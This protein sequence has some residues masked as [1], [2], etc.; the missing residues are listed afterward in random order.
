MNPEEDF[1]TWCGDFI[2]GEPTRAHGTVFCDAACHSG[3]Q[4]APQPNLRLVTDAEPTA[5]TSPDLGPI[6]P[7]HATD[8]WRLEG[9]DHD[10]WR[11]AKRFGDTVAMVV[12]TA[13]AIAW[14]L[15]KSGKV[16]RAASEQDVETAK[17]HATAWI[18]KQQ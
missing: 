13:S 10:R 7:E 1:C 17:A 3:Y 6:R 8:G 12:P 2:P 4:K 15:L 9:D 18:A 11:L 14:T 16:I 5:E